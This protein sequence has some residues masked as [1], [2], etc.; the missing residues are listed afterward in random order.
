MSDLV[1]FNPAASSWRWSR[2]DPPSSTA[3]LDFHQ[4]LPSYGRTPLRSLP[5]IAAEL[6]LGHVL[7]KDES[8]RFGLPSFKILGASYGVFRAVADKL[9]IAVSDHDPSLDVLGS[10]ASARGLALVTCTEG[11]WGRAVARMARYLGIPAK[12]FVPSFMPVTTR[13]K[14]SEEGAE[15]AVVNGNYDDSVAAAKQDAETHGS[16]LVMD[17]GWEGYE[18]I[19]QWVV[20]GYSTM[21]NESDEQVVEQTG[22]GS[23]THAFVPVGVGSIAQ[24]VTQHFK[25]SKRTSGPA[26]VIA[27]EPTGAASLKKSLE[28]GSISSI[29]TDDTIMCGMNCGTISTTAWPILSSG[30]DASVV[31]T[32]AEAHRAVQDLRA[33]GVD[34]GPCG[35]ATLAALRTAAR[36]K[37]QELG[38]DQNSLAVLFC[39]EGSREYD[40][41][42]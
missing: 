36:E 11:N 2:N 32:D 4:T 13:A 33:H 34:A 7:L 17:F 15:V 10:M 41:L 12:I 23:V 38:L 20:E 30:V 26:K 42:E 27:V 40:M 31:V 25:D 16:L 3:V 14:I 29:P 6:G 5:S 9:D 22:S 19:P 8:D 1:L 28:A 39:T 24:A 18:V 35:A 21:L 37:R